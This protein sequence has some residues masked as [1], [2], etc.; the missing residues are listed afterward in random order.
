LFVTHIQDP[1][2]GSE[3]RSKWHG[4]G[5]V[6]LLKQDGYEGESAV[7]LLVMTVLHSRVSGSYCPAAL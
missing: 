4:W 3:Q 6:S 2:D 7:A 5:D 1:Y